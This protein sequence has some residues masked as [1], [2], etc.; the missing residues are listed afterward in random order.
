LFRDHENTYLFV[1]VVLVICLTGVIAW[2]EVEHKIEDTLP[3]T[4]LAIGQGFST[5]VAITLTAIATWEVAMMF[6][7]KYR[8]RRFEEGREIGRKEGREIGREEVRKAWQAWYERL[9]A[10]G[11]KNEPFDEPPPSASSAHQAGE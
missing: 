7:E 11:D 2:Y 10:A 6:A 8:A 5:A 4:I 9:K 1:S 3:E